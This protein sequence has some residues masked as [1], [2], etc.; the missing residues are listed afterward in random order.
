MKRVLWLLVPAFVA[1][2]GVLIVLPLTTGADNKGTVVDFD[3]LKSA[4]PADW[5]EEEVKGGAV[6]LRIMQFR[7]PKA[8]DDKQDAEVA[9]FKGIGGSTKDNIERWKGQFVPPEGKTIDD[10][11]KVTE[12]KVGEVKVTYLDVAGT[13]KSRFP[14][15]DPN[16]KEE[17]LPGYRMLGVV[18]DAPKE[19]YHIK[20]TGPANTV[21]ANK[22]GFDDWIKGFK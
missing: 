11:A 18:F 1:L 22:Q 20:L 10:V 17:R 3:G 19:I 13:Y 12:F 16:A 2:A 5:K 15:F 4:V 8:K 9:V 21:E 6:K 14:P 7:V